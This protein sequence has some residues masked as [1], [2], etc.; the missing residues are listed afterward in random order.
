MVLAYV[1]VSVAFSIVN[2][3]HEATSSEEI[4]PELREQVR[5]LGYATD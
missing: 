5:A 4:P 1:I 3:I 2:P